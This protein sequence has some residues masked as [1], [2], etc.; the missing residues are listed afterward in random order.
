MNDMKSRP[1]RGVEGAAPYR[2]VRILN[3][4]PKQNLPPSAHLDNSVWEWYNERMDSGAERPKKEAGERPARARRRMLEI[5]EADAPTARCEA[6]GEVREGA[7][8][9]PISRKTCHEEPL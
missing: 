3:T 5:G 4:R 7:A 9:D 6:I 1:S 2:F 8:I